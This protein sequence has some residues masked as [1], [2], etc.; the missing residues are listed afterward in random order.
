M[1]KKEWQ[2]K[3]VENYQGKRED[4]DSHLCSVVHQP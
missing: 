1:K 3:I 4:D 2:D